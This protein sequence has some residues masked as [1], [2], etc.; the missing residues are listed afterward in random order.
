MEREWEA[1]I[2]KELCRQRQKQDKRV[3]ETWNQRG[4]SGSVHSVSISV[5]R[6]DS[7]WSDSDQTLPKHWWKEEINPRLC[8]R[9]NKSCKPT[10]VSS[11]PAGPISNSALSL[12]HPIGRIVSQSQSWLS[13]PRP[14][15][16]STYEFAHQT[17]CHRSNVWTN[18][19]MCDVTGT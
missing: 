15:K 12:F 8:K 18:Q 2:V 6:P 14:N 17:L 10:W 16:S 19:E 11:K 5:T 3:P 1:F 13:L 9:K 4:E 7:G